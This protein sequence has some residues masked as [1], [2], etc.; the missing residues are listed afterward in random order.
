MLRKALTATKWAK[1]RMTSERE[2]AL[3]LAITTNKAKIPATLA[4]LNNAI[5]QAQDSIAFGT[6]LG[7]LTYDRCVNVTVRFSADPANCICDFC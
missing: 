2:Y 3:T 4:A 5:V 1:L 7:A 6:G